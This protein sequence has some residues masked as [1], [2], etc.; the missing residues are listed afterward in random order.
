[1]LGMNQRHS[2]LRTQFLL[3]LRKNLETCPC[4]RKQSDPYALIVQVSTLKFYHEI[5]ISS[6]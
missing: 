3:I 2:C 5:N 4:V 6:S 1:M